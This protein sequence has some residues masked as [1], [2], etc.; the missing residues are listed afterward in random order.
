MTL[1]KK[2]SPS[3]LF[4]GNPDSVF[5][6]YFL[7]PQKP[8]HRISSNLFYFHDSYT[9]SPIY[10]QGM[11]EFD[12]HKKE[13]LKSCNDFAYKIIQIKSITLAFFTRIIDF[14]K[15]P[16]CRKWI[17]SFTT[18]FSVKINK[19][20]YSTS[21]NSYSLVPYPSAAAASIVWIPLRLS[22]RSRK[23]ALPGSSQAYTRSMQA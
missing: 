6:F 15:S 7:P 1:F 18:I 20:S 2:R 8:H 4:C 10:V 3:P 21:I 14:L 5:L 12:I 23:C 22:I 16:N 19:F 13:N 17:I 11:K 9:E